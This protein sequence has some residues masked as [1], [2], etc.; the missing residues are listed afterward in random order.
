[1]DSDDYKFHNDYLGKNI[2]NLVQ[3]YLDA[4][5]DKLFIDLRTGC[6]NTEVSF[7]GNVFSDLYLLTMEQTYIESVE[8]QGKKYYETSSSWG[9]SQGE[10]EGESYTRPEYDHDV[11]CEGYIDYG[12]VLEHLRTLYDVI[13]PDTPKDIKY[14][15]SVDITELRGVFYDDED[16]NNI[17][18]LNEM[19][20]YSP[21]NI[22]L[23]GF[24]TVT[25]VNESGINDDHRGSTHC[26]L[27]LPY[28]GDIELK[29]PITLLQ[30]MDACYRIKSHKWDKWYEL[31]HNISVE[32]AYLSND[33]RIV[34]S[35]NHGS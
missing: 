32:T 26:R 16:D 11:E 20:K 4:N 5:P 30:Y 8:Y 14:H 18:L 21:E 35:F 25:L 17:D 2:S 31:Y 9:G 34:V 6:T 27:F 23:T 29:L 13:V 3:A 24:E 28:E 33:I 10:K 15:L 7:N 1:M 12:D 19:T 22:V